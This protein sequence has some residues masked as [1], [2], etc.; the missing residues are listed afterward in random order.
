MELRCLIVRIKR[1][2]LRR[3]KRVVFL[4]T[5]AEEIRVR[6][7]LHRSSLDSKVLVSKDVSTG[8]G[9]LDFAAVEQSLKRTHEFVITNEK[10]EGTEAAHLVCRAHI[11]GVHVMDL[12]SALVDIHPVIPSRT[13]DLV[14]I[15]ARKGV[16][17]NASVRVYTTIKNVIEPLA[18]LTLLILISPI[19]LLTALMIKMTSKGPIVYKQVRAGLNGKP[20]EIL[21]FRSM[22]TDAEKDGP[23][24]ASA[25]KSDS[26][27][28]PIGGFLRAS[29]LDEIPQLW[30][31]VRGELSIVGPRPERPIFINQLD[32]EV[33]LFRLR[34]LVKPGITG[35]AQI[36]QGYANSVDDSR[37]KLEHDLYYIMKHSPTLD[38][39]IVLGTLG[40]IS[41][42]GTEGRKRVL[43]AKAEPR[44]LSVVAAPVLSEG[45][46]A[47][48]KIRQ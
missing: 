41:N 23:V 35:W 31:V 38:I 3:Q 43:L 6:N 8:D 16:Q 12:E 22:R 19:V 40:V 37:V 10:I 15:I 36:N 26:R 18:A 28:T 39:A 42:G 33:P 25:K 29:H 27:L 17:Q 14:R 34:T 45:A 30:N 21:K 7:A 1:G 9:L 48:A 11:K 44:K 24:W 5:P 20:F 2:G 32:A 13:D 46:S 47:A 4:V